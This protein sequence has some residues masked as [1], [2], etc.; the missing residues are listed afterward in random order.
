MARGDHDLV[1]PR[2][3]DGWQEPELA[4]PQPS[5]AEAGI[6][7]HGVLANMAPLGTRP[8]SKMLKSLGQAV[9]GRA[10]MTSKRFPRHSA[11]ATPVP[12][13]ALPQRE[14]SEPV[15][16]QG[17][18][19]T[20]T[21]QD[22]MSTPLTTTDDMLADTDRVVELAVQEAIHAHRWPTAYALRTVFDEKTEDPRARALFEQI[23]LKRASADEMQD[24]RSLMTRRK[25]QGSKSGTAHYYFN[26]DGAEVSPDPEASRVQVSVQPA[27]PV[28][29]TP[30]LNP[31][32]S[33]LQRPYQTPYQPAYQTPYASVAD[34]KTNGGSTINTAALIRR[35]CNVSP[36]MEVEHTQKKHKSVQHPGMDLERRSSGSMNGQGEDASI[37]HRLQAPTC[38]RTR[39]SSLSSAPSDVSGDTDEADL[40]TRKAKRSRLNRSYYPAPTS[41][42]LGLDDEHVLEARSEPRLHTFSTTIS[43]APPRFTPEFGMASPPRRGRKPKA[44]KMAR[45]GPAN[46][47]WEGDRE[48]EFPLYD[49][50]DHLS[51]LKRKA[52]DKT[53][54]P[55]PVQSS[56][57]RDPRPDVEDGTATIPSTRPKVRLLHRRQRNSRSYAEME[58]IHDS[59]ASDGGPVST[60]DSRPTTPLLAS[61]P[62]RKG[63]HG[64]GLRVK[65]S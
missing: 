29:M 28:T 14:M 51:T 34:R 31:F 49:A 50:N 39:S 25:R 7:R 26:G 47:E 23:Y 61:R 10:S 2:S 33:Q 60:P 18:L 55:T 36:L 30:L 41:D 65:T 53:N 38:A 16:R 40:H 8:T 56:H 52:R 12:G 21:E 45:A 24:F 9:H 46:K 1:R 62:L 42:S 11:R 17:S 48:S 64:T 27:I 43:H 13:D 35:T 58:E 3:A 37:R 44:G 20:G 54:D 63:K 59:A 22:A 32:E 57:E 19:P 6:E 4:P 15:S 5:F